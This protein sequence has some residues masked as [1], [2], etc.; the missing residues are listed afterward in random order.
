MQALLGGLTWRRS[1]LVLMDHFLIVAAVVLAV[2]V[3]IGAA[4]M[5]CW[6]G[7]LIWR[8]ILI[9]GV[10]QVCLHYCD[11]YDSAPLHDR[12]RPDRRAVAGA[13]RRLAHARADLLLGAAAGARP[14]HLPDRRALH[15]RCSSP[16]GASR[17]EW[18]S[19]RMGPHERRADRRHQR[20]GDGT[21][22]R[23]LRAP[24]RARRRAHRLRRSA[25]RRAA[26]SRASTPRHH[27][28]H[29]T[30]S[31]AIV[32]E[33]GV[34]RVVVS[35][36]DARGKLS[37][38]QLLD[39]KLNDGVR[40]DHLASVYEEYTGKIAVE[41]LRPSW[42]DLL[43]GLPQDAALLKLAKRGA[44]RRRSPSSRCSSL[45]PVMALVALGIKLTS[46]GPGASTTRRASAMNGRVFTVHKF[47]SMRVGRRE[48]HRRGLVARR[49]SA[50]DAVRPVPPP[51]AARR[52][53]AVL[54]R[55]ARRHEHRRARGP[56]G[57]SS[58]PSSPSEIP[59]Y[60]QRHVVRPGLTGWAQV[61]H[62]YGST[63]EDALQKL[64]FDLFYIK[65]MSIAFDLFIILETIK[66]VLRPARLVDGRTTQ[67]ILPAAR[68]P[69]PI[70]QR[71]DHRRGGLLPRQRPSTHVVRPRHLGRLCRAASRPTPI[72]LLDAVRRGAGARPRSSC[73]AGW[74]SAIRGLVRRIAAGRPR[75]RVA[76]LLASAR[77]RPRRRGASATICAA[78]RASSRTAGGRRCA[79]SGRPAISVTE[80]SLWALDVL[81]E[82]GYAYDASIFPIRHDR[83]G[84]PSAPP[85][86][87]IASLRPARFADRGA[88]VDRLIGPRAACRSAAATSGCCRTR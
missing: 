86:R 55:P 42:L 31:R 23:A 8:A 19:S 73:S 84:I 78:P 61:R 69:G 67:P 21:G 66:T 70:R 82:E 38:D 14:R 58:S 50:R 59:F 16:A 12:R 36:A 81:I 33:R 13:R 27:R 35:L 53:A 40:F 68:T 44:R 20:R 75:D 57:P 49:R 80:R 64:Q 43:R 15:R 17:F 30:T 28:Q 2:A 56:S 60:G 72:A 1:S 79:A 3:R 65:H 77:L 41:N 11:L 46:P 5:S 74:P 48:R 63:V 7:R 85:A 54:E 18:L 71:D 39:M 45:S 9:A 22:A 83:Y 88:R 52:A 10:L 24:A 6:A 76:Q 29:R 62:S 47:R 32:R 25:G 87:R 26:R 37:M 4:P 51:H 34:D